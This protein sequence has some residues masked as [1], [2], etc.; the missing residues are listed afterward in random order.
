MK[1]RLW[2]RIFGHR[3]TAIEIKENDPNN[4]I[5]PITPIDW[6][7]NCGLSKKELGESLA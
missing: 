7:I 5:T 2:C 6:C 4:H 3:F 1:I